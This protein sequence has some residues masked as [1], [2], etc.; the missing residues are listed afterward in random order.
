MH[1]LKLVYV[2]LFL[3]ISSLTINQVSNYK[4]VFMTQS[5]FIPIQMK[6]AETV[7]AEAIQVK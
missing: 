5:M 3:K 2:I 4:W 7:S 6:I 1:G